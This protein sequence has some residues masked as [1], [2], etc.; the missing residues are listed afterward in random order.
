LLDRYLTTASGDTAAQIKNTYLERIKKRDRMLRT[1]TTLKD[2][3]RAAGGEQAMKDAQNWLATEVYWKE[4][5]KR[6]AKYNLQT[7]LGQAL[8]FDMMIHHG[9]GNLDTR[10]IQWTLDTLGLPTTWKAGENGVS[11]QAF[12]TRLA[13]RRKDELYRQAGTRMAGLKVR[14]DFWMALVEKGDW[15]IQGDAQGIVTPKSGRT[16]NVKNPI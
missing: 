14:G 15:S 8:I 12:I 6:H 5:Q 11:E 2:L 9:A 4:A 3:L 7:P 13:Q 16:V 10:Y 1:D